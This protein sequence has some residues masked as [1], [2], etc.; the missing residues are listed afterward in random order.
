L[1]KYLKRLHIWIARGSILS[2]STI[3]AFGSR[4]LRTAILSRL[5]LPD[6]FGISIAIATVLSI[7]S[8]ATDLSI[9]QFLINTD[10]SDE[11][12]LAT[13]HML[14]IARGLLL[15]AILIV[16]APYMASTFGVPQ[17]ARSF[18]VAAICPFI[19]SFNHLSIKQIRQSYRYIPDSIAQI[20]AQL[21]ALA[22]ALAGAYYF[23]DHRAIVAS[24]LAE[25][26]VYAIGSHMLAHTVYRAWPDP[27]ML[28]V[29]SNFGVPLLLNGIGLAAIAQLDRMMVG[30]Y[31]GV[32]TLGDYA[33]ILS[34]GLLPMT[35]IFRVVGPI[36][37]ASL[38]A[39]KN[40]VFR[41][42]H[43]TSLLFI[44]E[45]ICTLYVLSVALTLDWLVPL[46]FGQSFQVSPGV[47]LLV[48][49]IAFLRLLRG[50]APTSF[51]LV[52]G[53]TGELALLNLTSGI[54]IVCAFW[55][56][57]YWPSIEAVLSGLLIG[58]CLADM[59]LFCMSSAKGSR[60]QLFWKLDLLMS[61]LSVAIIVATLAYSPEPTWKARGILF[62]VGLVGIAAQLAVGLRNH[63]RLWVD[64]REDSSALSNRAD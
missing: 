49:L 19:S 25:S 8:L 39:Q 50:S 20:A 30:S 44:A 7:A 34:L 57:H 41:D 9:D 38:V 33:V 2:I 29:A 3:V 59:L 60:S 46:I 52:Q 63:K 32:K 48:I 10:K 31:L 12:A 27:S 26:V 24:F 22:A 13:V 15:S 55:L 47:H 6:E 35:F 62:L 18:A 23:H 56:I 42:I 37:S 4:F 36:V 17:A 51:L 58:E 5:L 64:R 28:R 43:Y 1:E 21:A 45:I 53:K 14:S 11:K 16:I 40:L 61:L 54:G